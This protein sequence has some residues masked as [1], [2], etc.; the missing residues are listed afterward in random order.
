[1][2]A[3]R[4]LPVARAALRLRQNPKNRRAEAATAAAQA[5]HADARSRAVGRGSRRSGVGQAHPIT[6][7]DA[8][9]GR[10]ASRRAGSSSPLRVG[11][12]RSSTG[13]PP[14]KQSALGST[15]RGRS[16]GGVVVRARSQATDRRIA[17]AKRRGT[18]SCLTHLSA[19]EPECQGACQKEREEAEYREV[20]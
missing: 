10:V 5:A 8:P 7:A 1:E 16:I 15:L 17:R 13:S 14:P 9:R 2:P 3:D 19:A 4:M 20:E 11:S 12:L 6:F 18:A